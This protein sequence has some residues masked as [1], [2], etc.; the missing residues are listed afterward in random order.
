MAL[1]CL[2]KSWD[3]RELSC[4][5]LSVC[6]LSSAAGV[7][8]M[9]CLTL[10]P[11]CFLS[12]ERRSLHLRLLGFQIRWKTSTEN[13]NGYALSS[14]ISTVCHM[15]CTTRSEIIQTDNPVNLMHARI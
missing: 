3:P 10:I 11:V 1:Q 8:I 2:E 4:C 9:L 14:L 6:Y 5:G 12:P 15:Y 13:S 7:E